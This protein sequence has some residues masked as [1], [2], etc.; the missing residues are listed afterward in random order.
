[1][2]PKP[3]HEKSEVGLLET[4]PERVSEH[5][6]FKK[7]ILYDGYYYDVTNFIKRHPG[8]T[9]IDYYTKPGEDATCAILQ[10]HQRSPEKVKKIMSTLK[11]R[12]ARDEECKK[13]KI[14]Q[15]QFM[16]NIMKRRR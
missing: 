9:I 8:G 14:V 16:I 15:S 11:S 12:P 3:K 13:Y 10:F 6:P 4:I 5:S 7:E 1:M 2:V